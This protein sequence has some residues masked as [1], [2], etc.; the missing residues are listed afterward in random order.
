MGV[1]GL[2]LEMVRLE[3]RVRES[4]EHY[5]RVMGAPNSTQQKAI[6]ARNRGKLRDARWSCKYLAL[7]VFS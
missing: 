6:G 4:K 1:N 3:G 7:A 2:T 5:T